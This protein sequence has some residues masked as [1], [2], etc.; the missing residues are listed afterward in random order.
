MEV[1]TDMLESVAVVGM[2]NTV[3]AQILRRLIDIP[4]VELTP[5]RAAMEGG[6]KR[7]YRAVI[8]EN[9]EVAPKGTFTP[10]G[11]ARWAMAEQTDVTVVSL[12]D[13]EG[14]RLAERSDM[15]VYAYS[16]GRPQADLTAKQVCLRSG[17]LEFEA[18]THR[19]LLRVSVPLLH[20]PRLYD[21]LAALAGALALGA[22]LKETAARLSTVW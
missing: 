10:C 20:G 5:C 1:K 7:R 17:R 21:Y 13:A 22:P 8:V 4:V 6:A 3:T 12:D 14:R 2:G 9:F 11:A 18:L 16:D 19:E 15:R